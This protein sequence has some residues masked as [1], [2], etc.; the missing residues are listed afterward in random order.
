LASR[1]CARPGAFGKLETTGWQP[2]ANPVERVHRWLNHALTTLR[3]KFGGEWNNYVDAA[4]FSYNTSVHDTTGYAPFK[5]LYGRHPTLPDDFLFGILAESAFEIEADY[6]AAS[7]SRQWLIKLL[8]RIRQR[9]PL[10]AASAVRL[11]SKT[12][13]STRANKCC[14]GSRLQESL[15]QRHLR[16]MTL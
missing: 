7:S 12:S 14:T 13:P 16:T 3:P 6:A 15:Q 5:F 1:L 11:I 8:F 10:A 4:V 2:Q 9:W